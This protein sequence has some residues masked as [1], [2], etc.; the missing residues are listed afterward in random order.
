[1]EISAVISEDDARRNAPVM[2]IM[3]NNTKR[4]E[5]D[6]AHFAKGT[7]LSDIPLYTYVL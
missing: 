1:M 5:N 7:F 2:Y 4:K 6:K 3:N